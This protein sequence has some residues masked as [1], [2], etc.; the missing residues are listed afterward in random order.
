MKKAPAIFFSLCALTMLG[1]CD[2]YFTFVI[3]TQVECDKEG[4]TRYYPSTDG[5]TCNLQKCTN[6]KWK[7]QNNC[8]NVSCQ[9]LSEDSN[10]YEC[11]N[12]LNND[13]QYQF[14]DSVCMKR[15]CKDG[16]W[17]ETY[18]EQAEDTL[19]CGLCKNNEVQYANNKAG[20]CTT[21]IC[22]NGNW[23]D[24]DLCVYD[25][26]NVSCSYYNSTWAA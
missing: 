10:N 17:P 24:L 7:T 18:N 14:V 25:G 20:Y 21:Q 5:M 1:G 13:K 2:D 3:E 23:E 8:G 22:K 16:K 9:K 6:N 12:C 4:A 15:T 11:G 26:N 19:Q